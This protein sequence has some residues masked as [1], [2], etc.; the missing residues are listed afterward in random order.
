MAFVVED[1]TVVAD[2][3]SLCSVEY[4]DS[5]FTDRAIATWTGAEAAKQA[6]LIRATDYIEVFYGYRFR[7]TRLDAEQSLSFPREDIGQDDVVPVAIQ[8]ACAEYALRTLDGTPLA[9]D[10]T[11]TE[12]GLALIAESHK[13]GPITDTYRYA[14]KGPGATPA[15]TKSYPAA[16]K[17]IKPFLIYIGGLI[18]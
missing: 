17:L 6:A 1:G 14:S 13:T 5:Y 12:S 18:R 10:P 15:P 4:A 2:A 16:D 3:N 7:G 9:P 8:K 11:A